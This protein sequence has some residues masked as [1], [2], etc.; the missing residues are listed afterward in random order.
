VR[1]LSRAIRLLDALG[2][3]GDA[4]LAELT[5]AVGA[6]RASVH[7]LLVAFE[8]HGYVHHVAAAGAYRLGPAVRALAAR[9]TESALLRIGAPA[10]ADLRSRTGET[11]NLGALVGGRIVYLATL[12]GTLQPRMSAVVGAEVEPHATALGKAILS[13]A[14]DELRARL[15][16][17]APFPAYT[18]NTLTSEQALLDDLALAAE[19]GYAVEVEE[20]GLGATC[21][22]SPILDD[23]GRPVG[24]ISLSGVTARLPAAQHEVLGADLRDWASRIAGGLSG[25]VSTTEGVPA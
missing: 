13:V 4:S 1:Q 11:A 19:R 5:E 16:P 22:A 24:A 21:I 18:P 7:R 3:R 9:A 6:P 20:S 12:D 17:P 2:A 14:S 25:A 10:L 23:A 8:E 15:L